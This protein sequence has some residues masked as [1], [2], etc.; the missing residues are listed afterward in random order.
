MDIIDATWGKEFTTLTLSC[1]CA[2]KFEIPVAWVDVNT[3]EC[4]HCGL[5]RYGSEIIDNFVNHCGGH[6]R[7]HV[8]STW[9]KEHA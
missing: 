6:M 1:T 7:P 8:E 3:V 5:A 2:E 9:R 4:P